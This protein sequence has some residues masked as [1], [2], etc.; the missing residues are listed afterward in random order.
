MNHKCDR[1]YRKLRLPPTRRDIV[2]EFIDGRTL[3]DHSLQYNDLQTGVPRFRPDDA[4]DD[5]EKLDEMRDRLGYKLAVFINI[6]SEEHWLSR[7]GGTFKDRIHAFRTVLRAGKVEGKHAWI[8][9]WQVR[10]ESI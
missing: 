5:F 6:G 1:D 9:A 4:L 7:Y 8:A 2:P 3:I 10:N